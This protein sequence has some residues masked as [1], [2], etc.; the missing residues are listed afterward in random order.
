MCVEIGAITMNAE[1]VE[2]YA[3]SV[4]I[5][6]FCIGDAVSASSKH[7]MQIRGA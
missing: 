4:C 1:A 2:L 3:D 6:R 7:T 5:A